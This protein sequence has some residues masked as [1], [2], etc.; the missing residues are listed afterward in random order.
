MPTLVEWR[1]F[2]RARVFYFDHAVVAQCSA[3]Q[4]GI[5]QNGELKSKQKKQKA[6]HTATRNFFALVRRNRTRRLHLT[7]L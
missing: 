1:E 4:N 7:D 3:M 6:N 5:V 2:T